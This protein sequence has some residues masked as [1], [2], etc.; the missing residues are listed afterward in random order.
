MR[1]IVVVGSINA[2]LVTRSSRSPGPGETVHGDSFQIF[3][4]GKGANQAVGVARLGLPVHM[5]GLVGT[6]PFA[7]ELK[8]GLNRS[9]VNSNAVG[10]VPG[11]SGV[12]VIQVDREGQNRIT[13]IAGA[14]SAV[15]PAELIRHRPLLNTAGIILTQ[16]EIPI[17]TVEVLAKIAH[18][19]NLPLMLDPAPAAHL[20]A[21]LLH[22]TTWLTPNLS[23]AST[24]LNKSESSPM[25]ATDAI[26]M[27]QALHRLGPQNVLLKLGSLGLVA[28][29]TGATP[30]YVP[31]FKVTVQDTTAAGDALNAGFAAALVKQ[32]PLPEALRYAS[33]VAAISVSRE[34]A[35]PSLP[36][37][38]EVEAFL[39]NESLS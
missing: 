38:A 24:L 4:G 25:T 2:D 36:H 19:D 9:G 6:D 22:R 14:N 28:V 5:V 26:A 16:L 13:V 8:E 37:S 34:G 1:P 39:R 29:T 23:E 18:E 3:H 32:L 27:A 30:I 15:T 35:Q 11:A 10:T 20:S 31:S 7:A 33:A 17:N 12:A 21:E